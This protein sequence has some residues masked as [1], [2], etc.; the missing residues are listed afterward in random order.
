MILIGHDKDAFVFQLA[1]REKLLLLELLKAYPQT[2]PSQR[3]V[4]KST[5]LPDQ[6]TSQRLLDEALA[7]QRTENKRKLH[8]L[9]NDPHRWQAQQNHW[10]LRLSSSD[11]EWMLQVLNDIRVG[12]WVELG[13]PEQWSEMISPEKTPHVWKMELAGAFQMAFLHA[14]EGSRGTEA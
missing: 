2:P 14:L 5:Q 6:P 11:L 8:T 10:H 1:S 12:T 7:E 9:L 13:S 4:S 3:L